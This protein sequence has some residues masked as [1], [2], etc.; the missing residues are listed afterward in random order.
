MEAASM[1]V[2]VDYELQLR[3]A[4][5]VLRAARTAD[6]V[7]NAWKRH[8]GALGHRTLGRLLLGRSAAELIDTR[9]ERDGDA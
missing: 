5:K 4:E 1:A 8:I 9:R 2:G 3:D 6:D 7:R